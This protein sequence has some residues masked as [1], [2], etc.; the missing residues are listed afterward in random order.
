MRR[1]SFIGLA[2][3]APTKAAMR[4]PLR[5]NVRKDV[6]LS[7][8]LEMPTTKRM[9]RNPLEWAGAAVLHISL[10]AALIV[11]PLYTTGTIRLS[12]FDE[13]PLVAPPPPPALP[14]A[15][16]AASPRMAH[17]RTHFTYEVRKKLTT[18]NSIPKRV[19]QERRRRRSPT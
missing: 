5:A 19:S 3:D 11:L 1:M 6:F 15:G 7:A 2:Q 8:L 12:K 9:S 18:P 13:A 10:L 17:P 14:A 16:T 4:L